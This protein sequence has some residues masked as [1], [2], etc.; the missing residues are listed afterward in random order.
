[1]LSFLLVFFAC[2]FFILFFLFIL[3]YIKIDYYSILSCCYH[4]FTVHYSLFM[5]SLPNSVLYHIF[6]YLGHLESSYLNKL[7]LVSVNPL[8]ALFCLINYHF[9]LSI[10]KDSLL[11]IASTSSCSH[12]LAFS[13]ARYAPLHYVLA[14]TQHHWLHYSSS[15]FHIL[16]SVLKG[17]IIGS[18]HKTFRFFFHLMSTRFGFHIVH[19][20]ALTLASVSAKWSSLRKLL[21]SHH[22]CPPFVLDNVIRSHNHKCLKKLYVHKHSSLLHSFHLSS[23]HIIHHTPS[24][25]LILDLITNHHFHSLLIILTYDSF[26]RSHPYFIPLLFSHASSLRLP[27]FIHLLL[28]FL[29]NLSNSSLYT[30]I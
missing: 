4:S 18:Q 15:D 22:S 20:L 1:L 16:S 28:P 30:K 13:A 10:Y 11:H 29:S 27:S 24:S 8:F 17:S 23:S 21:K 25:L 26:I 5:S 12:H 9:D 19:N 14:I 3:L 6:S 2:L 7:H